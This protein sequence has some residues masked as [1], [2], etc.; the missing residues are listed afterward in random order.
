[1][2]LEPG[3]RVAVFSGTSQTPRGQGT[4]LGYVTVFGWYEGDA[5]KTYA[6]A[7]ERP[8][9]VPDEYVIKMPNN[10]KI[11][12]DTGEIVYGCQVWW[13]AITEDERVEAR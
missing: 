13:K 3:T 9:L 11:Q 10:P 5:L 4:L 12:L 1:M 2:R 7:E 8:P 6:A